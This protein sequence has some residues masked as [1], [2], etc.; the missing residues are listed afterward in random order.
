MTGRTNDAWQFSAR[1]LSWIDGDTVDLDVDVGF[2]FHT[3]ERFRILG[4]NCPETHSANSLEKDAGL[5]A[6]SFARTVAPIGA[7][8]KLRTHKNPD[9]YGRWLAEIQLPDGSDFA[10]LMINS[11]HARP[12]DGGTREPWVA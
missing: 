8:V 3:F 5:A 11:G 2:R 12:Y 1:I 9:K 6:L 10:S 4:I 7:S